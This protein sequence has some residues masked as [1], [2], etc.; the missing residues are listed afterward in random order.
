MKNMTVAYILKDFSMGGGPR[1][2]RALCCAVADVRILLYGKK[3][4]ELCGEFLSL[5]NVELRTVS[6]WSPLTAWKVYRELRHEGVHI[7]HFHH[8]LPALY[9]LPFNKIPKIITLHG[10][11]IRKYD[12]IKAPL[13]R[14]LRRS[15]VNV[16]SYTMQK[17][18]V[19]CA[20]DKN[21][22]NNVFYRDR[23]ID[24]IVVIPNVMEQERDMEVTEL[25]RRAGLNL[26]VVAR[27]DYQKGLDLLAEMIHQISEVD[28]PMHTAFHIYLIGDEQIRKLCEKTQRYMTYLKKTLSPHSYMR[29]SDYLLLPSRWEGL[30]MVALEALSV[31]TKVIAANTANLNDFADGRN[32]I[33][34]ELGNMQDFLHALDRAYLQKDD[35]VTFEMFQFSSLRVGKMTKELYMNTIFGNKSRELLQ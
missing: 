34:Y 16:I 18:V 13:C 11:H 4:G 20:E 12:F 33:T 24:K 35:P 23:D 15:C 25:P 1:A 10:L 26:L 8:L 5:P 31:G 27:Y 21:Y 2:V 17:I 14:L 19:L 6:E 30:P 22:M 7:I 9:F 28:K 32:I 29:A 3:G